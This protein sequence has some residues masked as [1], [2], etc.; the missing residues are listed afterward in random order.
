VNAKYV[1][2]TGFDRGTPYGYSIYEFEIYRS[3]GNIYPKTA[4][5]QTGLESSLRADPD[6]MIYPNPF[7]ESVSF[8]FTMQK[9]DFLQIEV[10]DLTGKKIA[11]VYSGQADAGQQVITWDRKE[12]RG[13]MVC[14][15]FYIYFLKIGDTIISEG[16]LLITE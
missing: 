14:P 4:C 5:F 16:K 2:M 1:K 3:D 8:S 12:N 13:L 6:V 9:S 11:V 15:G 10:I 7:N